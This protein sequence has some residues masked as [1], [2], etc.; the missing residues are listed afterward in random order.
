MFMSTPSDSSLMVER[1]P[2]YLYFIKGLQ[3]ILSGTL[4]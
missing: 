1:G 3:E 4:G 2:G